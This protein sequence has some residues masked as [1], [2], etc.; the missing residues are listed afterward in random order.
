MA[1]AGRPAGAA[2]AAAVAVAAL[3]VVRLF[4]D[5]DLRGRPRRLPR[6]TVATGPKSEPIAPIEPVGARTDEVVAP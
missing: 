4:D 5:H 1:A 3:H 6:R 2:L